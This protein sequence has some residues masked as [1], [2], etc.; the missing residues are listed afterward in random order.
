MWASEI[1]HA[2]PRGEK[3]VGRGKGKSSS[4]AIL[5]GRMAVER[6]KKKRGPG[7]DCTIGASCRGPMWDVVRGAEKTVSRNRPRLSFLP[8]SGFGE[9]KKSVR[10]SRGM[11]LC[12]DD[13]RAHDNG[14]QFGRI[15]DPITL[16]YGSIGRS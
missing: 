8:G 2:K 13:A 7:P 3:W 15:P 12:W 1:V 10:F 11:Y 6:K 4:R 14:Y 5:D 9:C 16:W